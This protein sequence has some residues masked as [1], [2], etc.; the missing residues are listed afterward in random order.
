MFMLVDTGGGTVDVTVHKIDN[1]KLIEV[2]PPSGDAWGSGKVDEEYGNFLERLF[3]T[4]LRR[5]S[6]EWLMVMNN[7][8]V[9]QFFLLLVL[10]GRY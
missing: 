4:E 6:E 8:E 2:V 10:I 1:G 3:G 5:G 9:T 7:F